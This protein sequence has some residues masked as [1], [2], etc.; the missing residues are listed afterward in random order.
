MG[1]RDRNDLGR[2]QGDGGTSG[3]TV[4]PVLVAWLV[5]AAVAVIF[6]LRNGEN[7]KLD[8]LFITTHNKT[9][10]LVITCIALG[11][12]LDRLFVMWWRRRR[13]RS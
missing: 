1:M 10:W 8:F 7:T 9:R 5:I 3:R 4:S 11:V 2:V 12:V 13:Q 6:F